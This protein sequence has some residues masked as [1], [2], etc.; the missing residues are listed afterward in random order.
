VK[1]LAVDLG[2]DPRN[3]ITMSLSLPEYKYASAAQQLAFYRD[4][5]SRIEGTPGIKTAGAESGGAN[6]FFQ[7]Q[8][9]APATPGQEP[10]AAFEIIT[11][12]FLE[13][14]GTRLVAGR[15]FREHD[16]GSA[17]PVA[18]ISETV[19]NRYWP[20]RSPLGSH[21]TIL[22]RVYSGQSAGSERSLEIVGIAKD[23]RNEDLWRPQPAI[24]VPFHRV[25]CQGVR[26]RAYGITAD[27]RGPVAAGSCP[28]AGQRAADKPG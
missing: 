22:S 6:V 7:P 25:R 13:A 9:H 18:I 14:M 20:Q 19:A 8:G 12:H 21:S 3:S 23:V 11:P 24:Y 1:L 5:I 26:G 4:L 28:I 2:I 16:T 17:A 10:T 15:A 27:E